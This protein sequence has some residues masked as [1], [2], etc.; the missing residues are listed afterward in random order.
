M[1]V[2]G[3]GHCM[4]ALLKQFTSCPILQ[5]IHRLALTHI[6][7]FTLSY[8]VTTSP[9]AWGRYR[10]VASALNPTL[11]TALRND[12]GVIIDRQLRDMGE[13]EPCALSPPSLPLSSSLLFPM[14]THARSPIPL[15]YSMASCPAHLCSLDSLICL[16]LDVS[17][18]IAH[19]A[20]EAAALSLR[21]QV[22]AYMEA[23]W[24]DFPTVLAEERAIRLQ[25]IR[26]R[27]WAG[28]EE[29]LAL[30]K[31]GEPLARLEPQP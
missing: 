8:M 20:E 25:G 4:Y 1:K 17:S 5:P 21:S 29:L 10:S 12:F 31:V 26:G 24:G 2:F 6:S 22:A 9:V 19:T 16:V 18:R 23:N 3:D 14:H 27:A 7:S 30:T 13:C 28:E 11:A 15:V